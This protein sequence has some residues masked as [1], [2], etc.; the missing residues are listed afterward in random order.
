MKFQL[1]FKYKKLIFLQGIHEN[2][3]FEAYNCNYIMLL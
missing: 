2:L 3:D 1:I